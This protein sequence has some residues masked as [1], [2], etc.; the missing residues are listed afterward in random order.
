MVM[1]LLHQKEVG[2]RVGLGLM[3]LLESIG[4]RNPVCPEQEKVDRVLATFLRG[5]HAT[6]K[7]NHCL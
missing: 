4:S 1:D 3:P 5:A 2:D 6:K 7:I